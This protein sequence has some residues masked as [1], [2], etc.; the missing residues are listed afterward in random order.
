MYGQSEAGNARVKR[1]ELELNPQKA[2]LT[3]DIRISLTAINGF[4]SQDRLNLR[5]TACESVVVVRTCI[6][7]TRK[8]EPHLLKSS[9]LLF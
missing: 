8:G 9:H 2:L 1:P 5:V 7:S 3:R 4:I 6:G